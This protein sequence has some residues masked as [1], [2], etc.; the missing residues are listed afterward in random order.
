MEEGF[1]KI[2]RQ[3]LVEDREVA[4][5][6]GY[7]RNS[8]EVSAEGIREVRLLAVILKECI[9]LVWRHMLWVKPRF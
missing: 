6:E 7:R 2:E 3:P 9:C 5:V 8:W 4:V 1:Q